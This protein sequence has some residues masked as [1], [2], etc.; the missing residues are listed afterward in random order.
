M[1]ETL[2][3]DSVRT[4][5]TQ[6]RLDA[7]PYRVHRAWASPDELTT[8]FPDAV[9]GSLAPGTRSTLVFPSQRIWWDVT[10]VE[11]DRLFVF[12]WPQL[13]DERLVTTVAVAI[14]PRGYGS[15]VEL[16]EGPFDLALP[17]VSAAYARSL[18]GWGEALSN[19]RAVIDYSVDLRRFRAG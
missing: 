19:L 2:T 14:T 7:P 6:H 10:E 16:R 11:P 8:W 18:L 4:I 13:P 12:R 17:D 5:S 3:T 1:V 15:V 9:E